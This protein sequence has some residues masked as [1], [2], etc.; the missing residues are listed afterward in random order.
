MDNISGDR[1]M[2][3]KVTCDHLS[4]TVLPK[5]VQ[6][7]EE[8]IAHVDKLEGTTSQLENDL[9]AARGKN[10]TDHIEIR[11]SVAQIKES[12]EDTETQRRFTFDILIPLVIRFLLS[13]PVLFLNHIFQWYTVIVCEVVPVP[14]P[15]DTVYGDSGKPVFVV[16]TMSRFVATITMEHMSAEMSKS[17]RKDQRAVRKL[18]RK[19]KNNWRTIRENTVAY[20]TGAF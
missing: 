5:Y 13:R 16:Q 17:I 10:E 11:D 15:C 3:G 2:S 12:L 19:N 8:L 4:P 6:G 7:M 20:Y 18:A 9:N 1:L 14:R